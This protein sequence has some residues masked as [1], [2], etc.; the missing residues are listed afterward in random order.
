[1]P[2][3]SHDYC[4]PCPR[5]A[6]PA[7]CHA[8]S[9]TCLQPATPTTCLADGLLCQQLAAHLRGSP[10]TIGLPRRGTDDLRASLAW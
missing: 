4:L 8:C 1:M 9:L 5:S 10:V 2:A 7:A 3:A 6:T